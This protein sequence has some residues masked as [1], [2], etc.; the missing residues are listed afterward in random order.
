L[1]GL[2][3][4]VSVNKELSGGDG[5]ELDIIGDGSVDTSAHHQLITE[6]SDIPPAQLMDGG[7]ED[8][9]LVRVGWAQIG[10]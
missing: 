1:V 10:E 7:S 3:Q 6:L 4:D 8:M 2:W 5:D 9:E